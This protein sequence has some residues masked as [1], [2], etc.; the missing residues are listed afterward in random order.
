MKWRTDDHGVG[1]VGVGDIMGR[2]YQASI[3]GDGHLGISSSLPRGGLSDLQNLVRSY[4]MTR[5]NKQLGRDDE[6]IWRGGCD[7]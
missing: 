7:H 1:K 3:L 4:L 2:I 6:G 5:W